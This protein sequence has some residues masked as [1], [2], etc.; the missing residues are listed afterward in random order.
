MEKK[1]R[2]KDNN[3]FSVISMLRHRALFSLPHSVLVTAQ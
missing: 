1:K 3:I 2:T